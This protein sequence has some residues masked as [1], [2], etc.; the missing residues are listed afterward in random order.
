MVGMLDKSYPGRTKTQYMSFYSESSMARIKGRLS[1]G[2]WRKPF[3]QQAGNKVHFLVPSLTH[4]GTHLRICSQHLIVNLALAEMRGPRDEECVH[5]AQLLQAAGG[6][7]LN[8]GRQQF[9]VL[10][11]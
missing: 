7:V 3:S 4:L 6:K 8:E 11:P 2:V 10:L 1:Q 5:C 9:T